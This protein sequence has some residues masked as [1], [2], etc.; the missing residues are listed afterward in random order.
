MFSCGKDGTLKPFTV[1]PIATRRQDLP[2]VYSLNGALY[3]ANAQWLI[4][5]ESFISPETLGYVMPPE[6]SADIDTPLD[7]DWV[8]FLMKKEHEQVLPSHP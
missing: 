6:R 4:Q 5:T 1:D 3:L 8:E 7:W 2:K